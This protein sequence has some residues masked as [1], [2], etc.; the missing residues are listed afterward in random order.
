MQCITE[1]AANCSPKIQL[2]LYDDIFHLQT[3]TFDVF[4]KIHVAF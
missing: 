4:I 2:L 1:F 3:D